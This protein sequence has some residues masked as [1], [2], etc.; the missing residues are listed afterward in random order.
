MTKLDIVR[1]VLEASAVVTVFDWL[2]L[3]RRVRS[4]CPTCAEAAT[5]A[6]ADGTVVDG[7]RL[8]EPAD[9]R[10]LQDKVTLVWG[11]RKTEERSVIRLGNVMVDVTDNDVYVGLGTPPL[12]N[13]K[14]YAQCVLKAYRQR[15]AD[16]ANA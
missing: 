16:K 7:V 6:L 14:H 1:L 13:G 15:V 5:D 11:G 10:W 8:P 3:R 12:H 2:R 4:G 9:A